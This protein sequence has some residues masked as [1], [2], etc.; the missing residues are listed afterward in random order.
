MEIASERMFWFWTTGVFAH[1]E[2]AVYYS[3]GTATG[4]AL[5]RR[6]NVTSWWSLVLVTPVVAF[7]IEGVI[8]PIIYTAGPFVPIF[9]A[10]FSFWHGLLAFVGLVFGVRSLLLRQAWKQLTAAAVGLGT[11]WAVWSSTLWLP[12]NV[13]DPELMEGHSGALHVLDPG[14]FARYAGVMTAV[15][16]IGHLLLG[17]V[18]PRLGRSS[19]RSGWL[20]PREW[21]VLAVVVAIVIGWTVTVPWAAPMFALY[22]WIQIV[23][24]RWHRKGAG[25][26]TSLIDQLHGRVRL[27]SVLPLLLMAPT[28]AGVYT[29]LWELDPSESVVRFVMYATIAVQTVAGFVLV[30]KALV[31]ARRQSASTAELDAETRD[32]ALAARTLQ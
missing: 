2:G 4:L 9:P 28:A 16:V 26:A 20:D 5:M 19:G 7:V 15:F 27:V 10:W 8:T 14:E 17:F 29:A 18:W 30:V 32:P 1:L 31:R 21:V 23:G 24:L 6:Y 13:N 11:F 12:E 22:C 3:I 25:G